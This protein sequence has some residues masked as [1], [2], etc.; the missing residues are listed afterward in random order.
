LVSH[1]GSCILELSGGQR[2]GEIGF[3]RFL[4][5]PA[6]TVQA[7]SKAAGNRTGARV[8]RRDI[9]A[10]Q[11]TTEIVLGG[12][13]MRAAGFGPVGR[14]GALGGVL[15]HPVLAVDAMSGEL[16]GLADV[17]I[18][19]RD[20]PL[21]SH[22]RNRPLAEKESQKW[23]TGMLR[24][25]EVLAKAS[26]ITVVSDR[27][28]DL[29]EDFARRPD[30]VHVLIRS[31]ANRNLANGEKLLDHAAALAEAGRISTHIAASPGRP[32][33]DATLALRFGPVAIRR[34]ERGLPAADLRQLPETVGL[35]LVDVREVGAPRGVEPIHW[36]LLTSHVIED[37]GVARLMLD[38]YRKRWI[39]EVFFRTLKSAGF[40]I[41]DTRMS[42]PAAFMNFAALAVIAA[43]TVTQMVRARDNPAEQ[44]LTDAFEADDKPLLVALCKDYEGEAPTAR[45]KNPHPPDTLA[46]ATWVIARLG[47]WTGYYGKPGPATLARG[48]QHYHAI[49]Y[50]AKISVGVV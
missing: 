42:D 38:F 46:F 40:Q 41:E 48:L 32:A 36:L 20:K 37:F 3:G 14:G 18:W 13:K 47:A 11:D 5:N 50:G 10:I 45:Q 7:L 25:S 17:A 21:A 29:Y 12:A 27:E 30:N 1:P 8:E 9:L 6:V 2:R 39:I 43:V 31:G 44:A 4:R 19:N 34:P 16:V 28:S 49:K 24:A 35:H 33:R 22:R 26:R 15:V 23:L